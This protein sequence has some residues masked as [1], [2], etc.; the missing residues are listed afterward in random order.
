MLLSKRE[1]LQSLLD[2]IDIGSPDRG[3][4]TTSI[5]YEYSVQVLIEQVDEVGGVGGKDDLAWR[6]RLIGGVEQDLQETY[7][8]AVLGFLDNA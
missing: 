7:V 2:R 3:E 1:M 4:P 5:R 6:R 8:D